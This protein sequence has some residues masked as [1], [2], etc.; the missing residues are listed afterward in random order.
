MIN[1]EKVK[2]TK[3]VRMFGD[4]GALNLD[5]TG[6]GSIVIPMKVMHQVQRGIVTYLQKFYRKKK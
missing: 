3:S 6:R 2:L 5:V 1:M 4:R